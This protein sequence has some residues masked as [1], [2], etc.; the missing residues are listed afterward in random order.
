MDRS[1]TKYFSLGSRFF[2]NFLVVKFFKWNIQKG[3]LA[4]GVMNDNF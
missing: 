4:S 3:R 1:Y 2:G